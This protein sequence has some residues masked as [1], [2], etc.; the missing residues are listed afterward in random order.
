ME[1]F[2]VRLLIFDSCCFC[3]LLEIM[4]KMHKCGNHIRLHKIQLTHLRFCMV[5]VTGLSVDDDALGFEVPLARF[6]RRR[7]G[8]DRARM[9]CDWCRDVVAVGSDFLFIKS[10][11]F[12]NVPQLICHNYSEIY[13]NSPAY[14][15]ESTR[16]MSRLRSFVVNFN[17]ANF[18]NFVTECTYNPATAAMLVAMRVCLRRMALIWFSVSPW[19]GLAAVLSKLSLLLSISAAVTAAFFRVDTPTLHTAVVFLFSSRCSKS[20]C[21]MVAVALVVPFESFS[22]IVSTLCEIFW[23]RSRSLVLWPFAI[24]ERALF[25]CPSYEVSELLIFL[26]LDVFWL[27]LPL[28]DLSMSRCLILYM[29]NSHGSAWPKGLRL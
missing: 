1:N 5:R 7:N 29:P 18:E 28:V 14:E 3:L 19:V 10:K 15:W 21:T 9:W 25:Q 8:C 20:R 17:D 26:P 6:D 23:T 13:A 22:F 16:V 24:P 2:L 12:E 27:A 4:L 11:S